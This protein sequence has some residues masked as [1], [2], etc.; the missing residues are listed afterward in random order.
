MQYIRLLFH[1]IEILLYS[2]F[3]LST[4]YVF[5][6]AVCALFY[7]PAK[8]SSNQ[9][10]RK[11]AVLIPGYKE[12]K[13]IVDVAR[14]SCQ[15]NYPSSYYDIIVIADSFRPDTLENLALLPV[16]VVEVSFEVST[17]TKALN[18]AMNQLSTEYD[19]AVILDADNIMEPD[20][21]NKIN[22]AFGTGAKILQAHRIAKNTNT[23]IAILDAVSEEMNNTIYRKGHRAAG[24]S[25]ALIGSGMAF[26][27][28]LFKERIAEIQAIGGFDKELELTLLRDGYTIEYLDDAIVADEKV[29]KTEVFQNQR[30]RWLSAQFVYAGRF[31]IP[32]VKLLVTKGKLDFFNKVVQQ[33]ILPRL[34]LLGVSFL[35]TLLYFIGSL[36]T[37]LTDITALNYQCWLGSLLL[38]SISFAIAIPRS[39]LNRRT[40]KALLSLP[41]LFITMFL[42]LFKLKGANKRFIHTEH[43]E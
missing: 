15:Q 24:L 12:D 29:H 34:L 39:Y 23:P 32:G 25:S 22:E 2:Y 3:L 30:R 27:Y 38:L 17:K 18:T 13:V 41:R 40:F 28:T 14:Q 16:K 20:F 31:I 8:I 1:F 42:L 36:L 33:L 37:D 26:D 35:F 10:F 4:L 9:P 11:I 5:I 43:G 21:L 6:F 19:I 7:K